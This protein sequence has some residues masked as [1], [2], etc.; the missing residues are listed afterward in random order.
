MVGQI[1]MAGLFL[2]AGLA[3]VAVTVRRRRHPALAGAG[4]DGPVDPGPPLLFSGGR[5]GGGGSPASPGTALLG[6]PFSEG[7]PRTPSREAALEEELASAPEV[8][9]IDTA[10]HEHL[11][12]DPVHEPVPAP[13]TVD[14][15]LPPLVVAIEPATVDV[16]LPPPVVAIAPAETSPVPTTIAQDEVEAPMEALVKSSDPEEKTLRKERDG[17]P[18]PP[19]PDSMAAAIRRAFADEPSPLID[20]TGAAPTDDLA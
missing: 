6:V 18:P 2:L 4:P 11:Q 8:P 1:R 20:D 5:P 3:L 7:R 10:E 15:S 9:V 14:L 19:A 17:S 13:A 12:A 16:T